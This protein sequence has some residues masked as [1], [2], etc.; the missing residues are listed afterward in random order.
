M[1]E[2]DIPNILKYAKISQ[3]ILRD[4]I[5]EIKEKYLHVKNFN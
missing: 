3:N 4:L 5:L 1:R 2:P